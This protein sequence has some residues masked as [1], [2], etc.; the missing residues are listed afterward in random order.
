MLKSG[1]WRSPSGPRIVELYRHFG[2]P[3]RASMTSRRDPGIPLE[4][5]PAL[6]PFVKVKERGAPS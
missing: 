2:D 3:E 5:K 4:P 1:F 6:H